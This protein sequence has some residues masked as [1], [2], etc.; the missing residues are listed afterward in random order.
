LHLDPAAETQ[1]LLG[2]EKSHIE[3]PTNQET[4]KLLQ[5]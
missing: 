4:G 1:Q 2:F 3:L 5:N